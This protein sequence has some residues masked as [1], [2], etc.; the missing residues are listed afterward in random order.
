MAIGKQIT[1]FKPTAKKGK[2]DEYSPT[3][4]H[5]GLGEMQVKGFAGRLLAEIH[6]NGTVIYGELRER[7]IQKTPLAP[8][9]GER[10]LHHKASGHDIFYTYLPLDDKPKKEILDQNQN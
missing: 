4:P 5:S 7:C 2:V 1:F 8:K 3:G 6:D 9:K 10:V